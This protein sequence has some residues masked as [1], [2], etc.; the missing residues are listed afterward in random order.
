MRRATMILALAATLGAAQRSSAQD[1]EVA[2]RAAEQ[3]V[4]EILAGNRETQ[5]PA[6]CDVLRSGVVTEVFAVAPADVTYRPGA[7]FIPHPLCTASW[8]FPDKAE[9]EAACRE[10]TVAYTQR[11]SQALVARQAFDEPLPECIRSSTGTEVTLTITN[12]KFD[13]PQAAVES[14]ES[15]VAQLEAGITVTVQGKD[16]T[17][18]V[19]FDDW[20]DGVGDLAA[21][22]PKLNELVVAYAGVRFAVSV[23]GVG[24]DAESQAQAI[25][26]ARQ[27]IETL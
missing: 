3:A 16:H 5:G 20:L 9:R 26:V 21:W 23:R 17:T 2:T 12:Q 19:D 15:S 4:Q 10:E 13:S 25:A 8:D 14:L 7:K 1:V 18:Q 6:V 11:K 22:A 24:D 27:V